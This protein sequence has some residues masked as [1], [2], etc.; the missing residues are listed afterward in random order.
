MNVLAVL[1][2]NDLLQEH[3]IQKQYK[4]PDAFLDQSVYVSFLVAD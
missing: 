4:T 1:G 2:N 3:L